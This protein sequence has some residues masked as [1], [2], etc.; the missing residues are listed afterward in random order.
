M[1]GAI[2]KITNSQLAKMK[3]YIPY[4]YQ[5]GYNNSM[6]VLPF[7]KQYVER[8]R[9]IWNKRQYI[10]VQNTDMLESAN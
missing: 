1:V 2:L 3:K 7:I 6:C 5:V 10:C 4:M 9:V 8:K